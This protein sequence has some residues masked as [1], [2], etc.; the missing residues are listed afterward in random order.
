M[1]F[2]SACCLSLQDKAP[3]ETVTL[4][5]PPSDAVAGQAPAMIAVTARMAAPRRMLPAILGHHPL[6]GD[7]ASRPFFPDQTYGRAQD[8]YDADGDQ[9]GQEREDDPDRPEFPGVGKHQPGE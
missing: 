4:G 8:D 7:A 1:I 6:A 3:P 5:G 2:P 9:V